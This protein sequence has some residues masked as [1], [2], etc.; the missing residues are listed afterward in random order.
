MAQLQCVSLPGPGTSAIQ[1]EAYKKLLLTL[2]IDP[3]NI[4]QSTGSLFI[5]SSAVTASLPRH[6]RDGLLSIARGYVDFCRAFECLDAILIRK[7]VTE[8]S[9]I[10]ERDGNNGLV[11]TVL[12]STLPLRQ[13]LQLR[14]VYSVVP[15]GIV[16]TELGLQDASLLEPILLHMVGGPCR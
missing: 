13:L 5:T 3:R 6:R 12:D 16:V 15:L 4:A 1:V 10:F 11:H 7:L 9:T 2:M 8:H 14:R